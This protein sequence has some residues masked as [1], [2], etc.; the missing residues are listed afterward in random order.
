MAREV[1]E[2]QNAISIIRYLP[3]VE[4][5]LEV[6]GVTILDPALGREGMSWLTGRWCRCSGLL[7]RISY[8]LPI[9]FPMT[10][11]P[12]TSK[13]TAITVALLC[14]SQPRRDSRGPAIAREATK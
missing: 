4:A 9:P 6:V 13:R 11:T 5:E 1:L 7:S 14:T 2:G 10:L 8:R 3:Q 12:M